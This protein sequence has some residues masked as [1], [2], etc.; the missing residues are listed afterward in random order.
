M[1][2]ERQ[3]QCG[4]DNS[5]PSRSHTHTLSLSGMLTLR[6]ESQKC[7]ICAALQ[8]HFLFCQARRIAQEKETRLDF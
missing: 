7:G 1:K 2:S 5:S 6:Y 4:D 3:L 8:L